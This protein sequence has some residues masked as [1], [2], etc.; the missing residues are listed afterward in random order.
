MINSMLLGPR[1]VVADP[2]RALHVWA[3]PLPGYDGGMTYAAIKRFEALYYGEPSI[4][5]FFEACD[6]PACPICQHSAAASHRMYL[7]MC[8]RN[9]QIGWR[10]WYADVKLWP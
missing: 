5:P 4:N 3:F 1:A 7:S 2:G 10:D 9:D 8:D 6:V